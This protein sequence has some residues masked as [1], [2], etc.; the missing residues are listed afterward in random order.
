[1]VL[2]PINAKLTNDF[3]RFDED[4]PSRVL[5]SQSPALL[6]MPPFARRAPVGGMYPRRLQD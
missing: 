5:I 6:R 2:V 4:Y 3:V 1:L